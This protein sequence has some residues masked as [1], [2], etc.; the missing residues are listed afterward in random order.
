MAN[1]VLFEAG[2]DRLIT[3]AKDV[4]ATMAGVLKDNNAMSIQVE[5][6]TDNDP[7]KIHKAKYGDNWGLSTA[8]SNSV[9]RELVANGVSADRLTAAGKGDTM[10][11]ASN[12][13]DEGKE[14][15]RRTEFVV[16]PKIDGLYKMYKN[17]YDMSSSN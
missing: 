3:E 6:H 1:K 7:V 16:V 2:R 10:P 17:G 11:V 5:G 13:T 15:N 12:D 4:L 9:L 8:R 14:K